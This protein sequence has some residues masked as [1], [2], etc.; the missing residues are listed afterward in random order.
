[1]IKILSQLLLIWRQRYPSRRW[2]ILPVLDCW[3]FRSL[4]NLYPLPEMDA[5]I[6]RAEHSCDRM[7][8]KRNSLLLCGMLSIFSYNFKE[9]SFRINGTAINGTAIIFS[10]YVSEIWNV[11]SW[12]INIPEESSLTYAY[13]K[14]SIWSI[15][16]NPERKLC[17]GKSSH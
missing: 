4:L 5:I 2:F 7:G 16:S 9:R 12:K 8:N 17:L 10:L 13:L 15:L 11:L 14:Y 6:Q 3:T 1:M